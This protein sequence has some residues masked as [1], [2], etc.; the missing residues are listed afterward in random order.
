M[1]APSSESREVAEESSVP[2]QGVGFRFLCLLLL[3]SVLMCVMS[4]KY[5]FGDVIGVST[6]IVAFVIS[7]PLSIMGIR[8]VAETDWNPMSGIGEKSAL[9]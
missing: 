5:V 1:V 4:V 9:Q 3:I 6:T 7:L 2:E 8:A